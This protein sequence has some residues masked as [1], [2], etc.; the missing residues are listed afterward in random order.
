MKNSIVMIMA[1]LC[2]LVTMPAIADKKLSKKEVVQ[3]FSGK[4]VQNRD[5][6][7]NR[8]VTVYF[9]PNGKVVGVKC[10]VHPWMV[11]GEIIKK[12]DGI[13]IEYKGGKPVTKFT[14]FR[15]GNHTG[16]SR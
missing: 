4:T 1:S 2:I 16:C 5:L 8:N 10:D 14:G 12:G 15:K 6:S 11:F 13:Y 9:N 3:L 7:H